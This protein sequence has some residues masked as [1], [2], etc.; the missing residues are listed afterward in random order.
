MRNTTMR[1]TCSA[2][3]YTVAE[4]D[5][6]SHPASIWPAKTHGRW[7]VPLRVVLKAPRGHN[8]PFSSWMNR[9]RWTSSPSVGRSVTSLCLR[10][11]PASAQ[12]NRGARGGGGGGRRRRGR[13]GGVSNGGRVSHGTPLLTSF[14][15]DKG[16]RAARKRRS[17]ESAGG[18]GRGA[19][20][21]I[22][23]SRTGQSQLESVPVAATNTKFVPSAE[24]RDV[25]TLPPRPG[26]EQWVPGTGPS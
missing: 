9:R 7:S 2:V 8:E 17:T 25:R 21:R 4:N 20:R 10:G 6:C 18:R 3:L 22:D 14:V 19:N 23:D 15:V 26:G 24:D 12:C 5:D 11:D 1:P 13:E 16:G